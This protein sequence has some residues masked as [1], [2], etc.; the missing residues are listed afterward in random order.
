MQASDGFPQ[1]LCAIL[2]KFR[3]R[4]NV[5]PE[6][7]DEEPDA[8]DYFDYA[9]TRRMECKHL[10]IIIIFIILVQL[11]TNSVPCKDINEVYFH[12]MGEIE[13]ERT[14]TE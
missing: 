14:L 10:F 5:L 13:C 4:N 3:E 12:I 8:T 9:K 2:K 1:L 7:P 6:E 11:S